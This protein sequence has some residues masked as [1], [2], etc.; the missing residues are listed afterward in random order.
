MS[1][2]NL[3]KYTS[4]PKVDSWAVANFLGSLGGMTYQEAVGNCE[5]DARSYGWNYET[6]GAIREALVEHFFSHRSWENHA[7]SRPGSSSAVK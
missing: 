1:I 4:R 3:E 5:M 6:S 7:T 2:M